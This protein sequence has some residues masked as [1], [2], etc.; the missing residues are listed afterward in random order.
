MT[1]NFKITIHIK[2][3]K[4]LLILIILFT[5]IKIYLKFKIINRISNNNKPL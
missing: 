1:I 3:N 2:M 4:F 5:I